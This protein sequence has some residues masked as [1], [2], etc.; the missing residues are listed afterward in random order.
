MSPP[1]RRFLLTMLA[2]GVVLRL[3]VTVSSLT[4]SPQLVSVASPQHLGH[5]IPAGDRLA[6]VG[7][8]RLQDDQETLRQL[9]QESAG[10][11]AECAL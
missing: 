1:A 6:V 8:E 3:A 4:S 2:V 9:V 7:E 5:L 10:A 11:A